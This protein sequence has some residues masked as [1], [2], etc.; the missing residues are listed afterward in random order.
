[1][2]LCNGCQCMALES[3]PKGVQAAICTDLDNIFGTR[4]TLSTSK[5]GDVG[6]VYRPEWCRKG[7]K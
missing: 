6:Q 4:R 5:A 7:E 1:M 2:K 3:W